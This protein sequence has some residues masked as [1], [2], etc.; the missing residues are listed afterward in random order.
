[1]RSLA[2]ATRLRRAFSYIFEVTPL[3]ATLRGGPTVA[4][5]NVTRLWRSLADFRS[6]PPCGP[7]PDRHDSGG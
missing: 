4:R 6:V 5:A 2:T 3:F 7:P 1:M